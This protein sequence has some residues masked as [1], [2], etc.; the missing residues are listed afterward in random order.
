MEAQNPLR[1]LSV[2]PQTYNP[3]AGKSKRRVFTGSAESVSFMFPEGLGLQAGGRQRL[4]KALNDGLWSLHMYTH[5]HVCMH[6]CIH[7]QRMQQVTMALTGK[8]GAVR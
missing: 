6:A 8:E 4:G 5:R 1:K 2:M 7:R 3:S